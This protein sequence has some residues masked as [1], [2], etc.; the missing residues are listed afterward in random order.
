MCNARAPKAYYVIRTYGRPG[1]ILTQWW[2]SPGSILT[3]PIGSGCCS[4]M[5]SWYYPLIQIQVFLQYAVK[6]SRSFT[7]STV[8]D[9]KES[10]FLAVYSSYNSSL[11]LEVIASNLTDLPVI[12]RNYIYSYG[13]TIFQLYIRIVETGISLLNAIR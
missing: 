4:D 12:L 5:D 3:T 1:L 7:T 13:Y 11:V 10:K 9:R 2:D 6:A 8:F